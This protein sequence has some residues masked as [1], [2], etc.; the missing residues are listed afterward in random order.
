ML[1]NKKKVGTSQL[2]VKKKK[3]T[4]SDREGWKVEP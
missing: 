3:T 1:E 4:Q 2:Y